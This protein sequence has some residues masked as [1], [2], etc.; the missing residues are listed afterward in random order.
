MII[1]RKVLR[2]FPIAGIC[3][4][5]G[6]A[7]GA[8]QSGVE[9]PSRQA[10]NKHSTTPKPVRVVSK[11]AR[12]DWEG[13]VLFYKEQ[14]VAGWT[15]QRCKQAAG[16][17]ARVADNHKS[18]VEARYNAGLSYQHCGMKDQ[19]KRQYKLANEKGPHGPSLS[20]L[21]E[22]LFAAGNTK[23]AKEHWERAIKAD[24][25]LTAARNNLAWLGLEK[26]RKT[27]NQRE[28]KQL[29]KEVRNQLSSVLAVDNDN[30]KAY[31]LYGLVYL[32]GAARN[33]D[34]LGLAKLLLDEG[35]KRSKNYA[36][37]FNA[38]GLLYMRQGNLGQALASFQKA[39]LLDPD[40][41]EARMNV[42]SITLGFRKY[43][44]AAE[45]FQAVLQKQP[46]S[47][48]AHIGLGKAQRGLRQLKDAE[49]SY[50]NARELDDTRGAAYFNL[51]VLY[52]DFYAN[53]ASD[54]KESQAHY[55][56]ARD[57]FQRYLSKPDVTAANKREAQENISDC[58]KLIKQLG[59]V[60]K[61]L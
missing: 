44:T 42:G 34:R 51:G 20:N 13:A 52:K 38:R 46:N 18:L 17:F 37:L 45:Q 24:S 29:E 22:L 35:E 30:V 10:G 11:G 60:I 39:V 16:R 53:K 50:G 40:F 21:G 25:K 4:L 61:T 2:L 48:D 9:N 58:D 59:E 32:E 14:K 36:P 28:W 47:Y 7:C 41:V 1:L 23:A 33:R 3:V 57:F 54:L 26:L 8:K 19:A 49:N 12:E 55:K 56:R 31:V 27:K 15:K 43:Q 6:G 5:I